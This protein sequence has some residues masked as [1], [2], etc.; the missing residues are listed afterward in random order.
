MTLTY[1]RRLSMREPLVA[2]MRRWPILAAAWVVLLSIDC[3]L[4]LIGWR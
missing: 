2:R 1:H 3:L 4:F